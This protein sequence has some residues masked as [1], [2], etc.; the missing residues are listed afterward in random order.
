MSTFEE[1][2]FRE[3]IVA[4]GYTEAVTRLVHDGR[5][6]EVQTAIGE[7]FRTDLRRR[8]ARAVEFPD[9]SYFS[10]EF[11]MDLQPA[12][13]DLVTTYM[14]SKVLD[15]DSIVRQNTK[16]ALTGAGI[17]SAST[18]DHPGLYRPVLIH[19]G[20]NVYGTLLAAGVEDYHFVDPEIIESGGVTPDTEPE[21]CKGVIALLDRIELRDSGT[22]I[23]LS[24]EFVKARV[25]IAVDELHFHRIP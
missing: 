18:Y 6:V 21:P 17:I 16:L 5:T 14:M 10:G 19:E 11:D 23:L 3:L 13:A 22:G 25:P 9:D 7:K 2:A 1:A 12:V 24:D 20:L 4:N 8:A 15:P